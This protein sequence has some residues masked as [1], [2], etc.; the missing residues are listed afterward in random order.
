ME[1]KRISRRK[2]LIIGGVGLVGL[3]GG[4]LW[5]MDG[6]FPKNYQKLVVEAPLETYRSLDGQYCV[7]EGYPG[8]A[9]HIPNKIDPSYVIGPFGK[10]YKFDDRLQFNLKGLSESSPKTLGCVF[11]SK[12]AKLTENYEQALLYLES[13]R[14]KGGKINVYGILDGGDSF[15][16]PTFLGHFFEGEDS[17][18]FDLSTTTEDPNNT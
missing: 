1:K 6:P 10:D 2:A 16:A 9:S 7:V 4:G 11:Y 5:F 17:R 3:V 15:S 8:I 14:A 13:V 18:R 12:D